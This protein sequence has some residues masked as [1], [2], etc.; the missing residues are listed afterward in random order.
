MQPGTY[1]AVVRVISNRNPGDAFTRLRNLS[2]ARVV[3]E[4]AERNDT[5]TD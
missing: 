3:V 5:C 2:R 4:Q 1:F